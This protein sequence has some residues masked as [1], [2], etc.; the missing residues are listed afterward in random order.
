MNAHMLYRLLEIEP[1][2]SNFSS[3]RQFKRAHRRTFWEF[4]RYFIELWE[5]SLSFIRRQSDVAMMSQANER[6]PVERNR[7]YANH[8]KPPKR[9][10]LKWLQT[11]DGKK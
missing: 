1:E 11:E 2:L 9:N 4:L 8:P 3:Y 10:I 5:P 7:G 6:E